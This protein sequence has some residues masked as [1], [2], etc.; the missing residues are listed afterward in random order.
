MNLRAK[1]LIGVAFAVLAYIMLV[2]DDTQTIE[3][4]RVMTAARRHEI[5]RGTDGQARSLSALLKT[6]DRL[7]KDTVAGAMFAVQSWYV[8]PPA[9]PPARVVVQAPPPP[10]APPLPF[11]FMGS[12]AA[13]DG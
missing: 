8:A 13:Q 6:S 3:P 2:A 7:V 9:A 5:P 11:V 12:F 1:V 10:S 4:A